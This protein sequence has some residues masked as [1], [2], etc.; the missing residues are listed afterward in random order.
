MAIM[1]KHALLLVLT[2]G[3]L[4]SNAQHPPVFEGMT[5]DSTI[6]ELNDL[7]LELV[8]Y[9]YGTQKISFLAIHDDEDTGVKAAFEYIRLNGGDIV[10]CQY[11]GQR[12]YTFSYNGQDYQTDPNSIYSRP[13]IILGLEKYGKTDEVVTDQLEEVAKEILNFYQPAKL[14][15]IF[16]LHNN[17]DEGFGI[18]SYLPGADLENVADSVHINPAMDPDDLILVTEKILFSKLKKENV[19]VVLQHQEAED[20]GSLSI[21]AMKNRI[22]YLN[23]EVQHGHLEDNVMLIEAGARALRESY[24]ALIK[25]ATE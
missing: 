4:N 2:C 25:K 20:G 17:A 24:P 21:Y 12:N 23:V 19:N 8:K 15:Y 10:D 18:T 16:T 3:W 7:P 13:G 1:M 5:M 6:L 11:G 9:K 22:P 14:G